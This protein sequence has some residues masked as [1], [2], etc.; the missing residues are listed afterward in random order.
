MTKKVK[1]K[2]LLETFKEKMKKQYEE[3]RLLTIFQDEIWAD[4]METRNIVYGCINHGRVFVVFKY[5]E[6]YIITQFKTNYHTKVIWLWGN[7]TFN[8]AIVYEQGEVIYNETKKE[9]A[10]INAIR[11][12]FTQ[13]LTIDRLK[14]L[15]DFAKEIEDYAEEASD[16]YGEEIIKI[17]RILLT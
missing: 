14:V 8:P 2:R 10:A 12:N 5:K 7:D 9:N 3:D 17:K 16:V 13:W 6:Q 1:Y 15:S 11:K 4:F